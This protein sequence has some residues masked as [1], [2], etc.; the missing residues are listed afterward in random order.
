MD[1]CL[2]G[3]GGPGID[4]SARLQ[5]MTIYHFRQFISSGPHVAATI[6]G[7]A[8]QLVRFSRRAHVGALME[9]VLPRIPAVLEHPAFRVPMERLALALKKSSFGAGLPLFSSSGFL[10]LP[11]SDLTETKQLGALGAGCFKYTLS[12]ETSDGT[13][14]LMYHT[15]RA[16]RTS[17]R[18]HEITETTP[19][20][21]GMVQRPLLWVGK[22]PPPVLRRAHFG[23]PLGRQQVFDFVPSLDANQEPH[24]TS[25]A[26]AVTSLRKTGKGNAALQASVSF[27]S[28]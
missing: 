20:R 27:C 11:G 26:A 8:L 14:S 23:A 28:R 12:P 24:F 17:R 13:N 10:Q 6:A 2:L 21:H 25:A 15:Q 1:A 18:L 3:G 19:D 7:N 9:D 5:Q 16:R 4:K 22:R